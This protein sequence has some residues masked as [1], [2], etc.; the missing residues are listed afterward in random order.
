MAWI[1]V[2]SCSPENT[3]QAPRIRV[4]DLFVLNQDLVLGDPELMSAKSR[5]S[6]HEIL[7]G[8]ADRI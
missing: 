2:T 4:L 7:A 3:K 6:M 1:Q 5:I 8:P